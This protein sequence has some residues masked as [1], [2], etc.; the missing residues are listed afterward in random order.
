MQ[1]PLSVTANNA[2][3]GVSTTTIGQAALAAMLGIL[4]IWAVGF[5]HV[6][7]LHNAAHDTRHSNAFPCH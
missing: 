2:A 4:L 7:V 6:S 1:S 5:S 3:A